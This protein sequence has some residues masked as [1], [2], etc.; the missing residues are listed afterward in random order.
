MSVLQ[1]QTQLDEQLQ[2]LAAAEKRLSE[3]IKLRDNCGKYV[4][5]SGRE[6]CR[7]QN[8][9]DQNQ[10]KLEISNAKEQIARLQG[11]INNSVNN[12]NTTLVTQAAVQQSASLSDP[13]V[14]AAIGTNQKAQADEEQEKFLI[15]G[16]LSL[17]GLIV[18]ALIVFFVIKA[19]K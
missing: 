6:K 18:V 7:A 14:I 4:L 16:G 12:A 8:T 1:Y 17:G 10:K 15:I 9:T 2:V 11:L 3:L 19:R 13:S 5:K